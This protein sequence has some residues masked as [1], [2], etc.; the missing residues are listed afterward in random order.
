[1]SKNRLLGRGCASTNFRNASKIAGNEL[2]ENHFVPQQKK[3]NKDQTVVLD[4]ESGREEGHVEL[5]RYVLVCREIDD[6][7]RAGEKVEMN[8][9][10]RIGVL[11]HILKRVELSGLG[12]PVHLSL[13]MRVK[14]FEEA[15][16]LSIVD[17]KKVRCVIHRG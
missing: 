12:G 8:E 16:F 1:M 15:F 11:E 10:M 9:T 17:T 2:L 6:Y 13:H 14:I 3:I 4:M 5:N 7:S